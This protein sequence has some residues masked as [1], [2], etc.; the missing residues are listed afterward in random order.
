MQHFAALFFFQ[1]LKV[2]S[3]ERRR[4]LLFLRPKIGPR[5]SNRFEFAFIFLLIMIDV[6]AFARSSCSVNTRVVLKHQASFMAFRRRWGVRVWG[7]L[8]VSLHFTFRIRTV[9][10]LP[11]ICWNWYVTHS[12]ALHT[13]VN[14]LANHLI[15]RMKYSFAF[16]ICWKY[17]FCHQQTFSPRIMSN[18]RPA[19]H[20]GSPIAAFF[21]DLLLLSRVF[22]PWCTVWIIMDFPKL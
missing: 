14:I 10:F 6:V 1:F 18:E 13:A 21:V 2:V 5:S 11:P 8:S 17:A 20:Y 3:R 22:D 7:S 9:W 19:V 15:E 12:R 16:S 4:L